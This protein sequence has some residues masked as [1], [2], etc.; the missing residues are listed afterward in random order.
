MTEPIRCIDVMDL[1]DTHCKTQLRNLTIATWQIQLGKA[2][3]LSSH[4]WLVVNWTGTGNKVSNSQKYPRAIGFGSPCRNKMAASRSQ[5]K[6]TLLGAHP[7]GSATSRTTHQLSS[8]GGAHSPVEIHGAQPRKA[9]Q[10]CAVK[11]YWESVEP[12][13]VLAS[14]L[15][16]I[17]DVTSY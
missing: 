7:G 10:F 13:W 3:W 9:R 12:P 16:P 2:V 14:P 1:S 5:Q 4:C 15:P 6:L 17:N 11:K 8:S